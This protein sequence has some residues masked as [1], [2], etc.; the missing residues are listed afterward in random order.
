MFNGLLKSLKKNGPG[1]FSVV[2]ITI[3]N[4][5]NDLLW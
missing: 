1:T 2:T 4:L 3:L 5:D